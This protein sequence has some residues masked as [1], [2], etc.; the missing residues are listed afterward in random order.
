MAQYALPNASIFNSSWAQVSGGGDDDSDWHD[1]LDEGFGAGRGTGSGPDTTTEWIINN[2]GFGS[3]LV[4]GLGAVTDPSSSSGHI[5]RTRN[6]RNPGGARQLDITV[7]LRDTGGT[8]AS[9]FEADIGTAYVTRGKTLSSSEADSISDYSDLRI[10]SIPAGVGGGAPSGCLETAHE[11][12][13]PDAAAAIV[14]DVIGA[15][16]IPFAR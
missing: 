1:E 15:G 8:L 5:F 7:E 16:V 12:E 10:A 14:R 13:C 9:F 2:P 11:F 4:T 6:R 3:P